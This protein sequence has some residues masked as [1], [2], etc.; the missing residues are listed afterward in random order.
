MIV[1][2]YPTKVFKFEYFKTLLI[3]FHIILSFNLIL[4]KYYHLLYRPNRRSN[5]V[6]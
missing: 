6:A 2:I 3:N 4:I 5:L 1:I